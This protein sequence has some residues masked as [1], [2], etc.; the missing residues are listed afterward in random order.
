MSR[1]P[2]HTT[3]HAVL[4]DRHAPDREVALDQLAALAPSPERLLWVDVEGADVDDALASVLSLAARLGLQDA[5]R[6]VRE[7]L[8]G[9]PRLRN[10]DDWFLVQAMAVRG[11]SATRVRGTP[12]LLLCGPGVVL[13][14]H[15][16][17]LAFLQELRAREQADSRI[18]TLGAESFAASLLGWLLDGYLDAVNAFEAEVDRLEVGLLANP[19]HRECLPELAALRRGASRIRRLLAPHRAVF[20]AMA[21]PDFRPDADAEVERQFRALEQ[22]FERAVD[23][24]ENARDLLVGTFELYSTR[25]AERTNDTMRALTFVTVLLGTLAVLAGLLGMNFQA[26][27]FDSGARGFWTA[28][29]GMGVV[30]VLAVGVARWRRWI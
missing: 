26:P 2:A 12:L 1:A 14:A 28:V 13:T 22:R 25:S 6:G 7:A 23:A 21:R 11:D 10:H 30:A 5:E 15:L 9:E 16:G 3:V 18:G 19:R 4:F 29:L 8:D 20:G 24:A 27:F 17:P